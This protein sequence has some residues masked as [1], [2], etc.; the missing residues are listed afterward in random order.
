MIQTGNRF[1]LLR[2]EQL[3]DR[4]IEKIPV[5]IIYAAFA[6]LLW[7]SVASV[8][9]LTLQCLRPEQLLFTASFVST[10]IFAFQISLNRNWYLLRKISAK[11]WIVLLFTGFLNP[12]LYYL[13]LF[14]AYNRLP[15]QIAQPLNYTWPLILSLFLAILEKRKLKRLEWTGLIFG[16]C[17]VFFVSTKGESNALEL[18]DIEGVIIALISALV[19]ALYWVLNLKGHLNLNLKLFISSLFGFFLISGYLLY[20][21]IP[22]PNSLPGITG[23]VYIG[24]FEMG[25]TFLLWL[26]ALSLADKS[27][28]VASM[29]NLTPVLSLIFI[30]VFLKETI[31][32]SAFLG[33]LLI[34]TGII[35]Q[36]KQ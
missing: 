35:I 31:H 2:E 20:F 17:G 6:V 7:S 26:K 12:F 15:A 8:F 18:M 21:N 24:F 30:S 29:A 32:W 4:I 1:L 33:L 5:S 28:S 13:L 14:H 16:L 19:W 3:S 22:L 25:I 36:R 9:K 34:M 10:L 27:A 11:I 23:A